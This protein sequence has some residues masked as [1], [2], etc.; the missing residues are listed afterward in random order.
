M[1]LV[2]AIGVLV[3]DVV[4]L[5]TMLI[6]LLRHVSGSSVG[7]WKLLYQHCIIWIVLAF[8]AEIP[9]VVLLIRN[10]NDAMN[11]M[12]VEVTIFILSIGASRMHRSLS[13]RG[14]IIEYVPSDL[15]KFLQN[16]PIPT[17][18]QREVNVSGPIRF[19][20]V[21]QSEV[22]RTTYESPVF[23]PADHIQ[24]TFVSSGSIT[25]AGHENLNTKDDADSTGY[26]SV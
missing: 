1:A 4:L 14:C 10:L 3:V 11:E 5:L 19:A 15:S 9:L 23:L 22:A 25:S 7:I 20:S 6:G 24:V 17:G 13:D 26:E 18:Q 16:A 2:N 21:T 8:F 12:F